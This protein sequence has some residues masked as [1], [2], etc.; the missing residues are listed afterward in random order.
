M[1]TRA[2][3]AVKSVIEFV[4][5][6]TGIEYI[7]SGVRCKANNDRT[8]TNVIVSTTSHRPRG[9]HPT[10][11]IMDVIDISIMIK[12]PEVIDEEIITEGNDL[13]ALDDLTVKTITDDSPISSVICT[14]NMRSE[15]NQTVA[16]VNRTFY[17]RNA[18]L[19]SVK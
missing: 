10:S 12:C 19:R 9:E 15:F 11:M 14:F 17:F 3:Y 8:G 18:Y 1:S 4:L 7:P 13:S 2:T 6:S 5:G 16:S